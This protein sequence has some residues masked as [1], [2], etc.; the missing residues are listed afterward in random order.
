MGEPRPDDSNLPY[1]CAGLM[2]ATLAGTSRHLRLIGTMP[3][4]T[5]CAVGAALLH[6]APRLQVGASPIDET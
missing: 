3:W 6:P 5:T 4:T 1:E 2:D